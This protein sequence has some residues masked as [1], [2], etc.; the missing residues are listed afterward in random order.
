MASST[1]D[2]AAADDDDEQQLLEKT[3]L[4]LLV[5]F[6][7]PYRWH[8]ATL[9]FGHIFSLHIYLVYI[10][11]F[12]EESLS[13]RLTYEHSQTKEFGVQHPLRGKV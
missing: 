8:L 11:F 13:D 1:S 10:F 7:M 6:F 2:A 3:G 5:V 4:C 12:F 9:Q